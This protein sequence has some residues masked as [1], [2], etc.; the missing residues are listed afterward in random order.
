[1][2]GLNSNV[3]KALSWL[4]TLNDAEKADGLYIRGDFVTM[5]L[6]H[7]FATSPGSKSESTRLLSC[8]QVTAHTYM[9]TW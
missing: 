3:E 7:L 4:I 1:M 8:I 2:G 6:K 9:L 5:F